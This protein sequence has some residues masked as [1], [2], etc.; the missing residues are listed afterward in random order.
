MPIISRSVTLKAE[1]HIE[2]SRLGLLLSGPNFLG[3]I[4][5]PSISPRRIDQPF[6]LRRLLTLVPQTN[7]SDSR[8]RHIRDGSTSDIR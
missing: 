2:K 6:H 1:L 5:G 7:S 8:S 3:G 4:R